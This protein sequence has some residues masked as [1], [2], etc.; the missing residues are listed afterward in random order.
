MTTIL[1]I[2]LIDVVERAG[3]PELAARLRAGDRIPQLEDRATLRTEYLEL[4]QALL[5]PPEEF[6][7]NIRACLRR[8]LG[9]R[10]DN[11]RRC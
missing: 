9:W 6:E 7:P 10:I 3:M 8:R 5:C 1:D 11:R 4:F 2:P